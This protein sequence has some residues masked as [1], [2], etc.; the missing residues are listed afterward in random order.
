M[1][2]LLL[3]LGVRRPGAVRREMTVRFIP[4]GVRADYVVYLGAAGGRLEVRRPS[5]LVWLLGADEA[6]VLGPGG[7]ERIER[8]WQG[9]CGEG[10]R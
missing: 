2:E 1:R 5:G 4:T 8:Q 6:G 10:A 9:V 7:L 3:D